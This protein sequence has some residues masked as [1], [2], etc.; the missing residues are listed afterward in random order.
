MIRTYKLIIFMMSLIIL[1]MS[2]VAC[3]GLGGQPEIVSTLPPPQPASLPDTP[4]NLRLGAQIYAARCTECHGVNG[5]GDGQLVQDGSVPNPGNFND[6]AFMMGKSPLNY[7]NVITNG[8]IQNLMPPWENALTEEERWAVAMY[9]YTLHYGDMTQGESLIS[10]EIP[11]FYRDIANMVTLTDAVL[12]EV[13]AQGEITTSPTWRELSTEQQKQA[14]AYVRSL[15]LTTDTALNGTP[16][17]VT[18]EEIPTQNTDIPTATPVASLG[19]GNVRG[20]VSAG[21]GGMTLPDD[22]V[23]TL[24][25]FDPDINE[26]TY[27]TTIQPDYSFQFEDIEFRSDRVY[28]ATTEYNGWTFYSR[29]TPADAAFDELEL[30]IVV[31]ETTNDANV[32]DVVSRLTQI[33]PSNNRFL[34]MVELV[35]FINTSDK[36][37]VGENAIPGE[38]LETMQFNLPPGAVVTL[39][40]NSRYMVDQENFVVT[41]MFPIPPGVEQLFAISYLMPYDHGAI[42]EYPIN[43]A[44]NGPMR[45]LIN[46]ETIRAQAPWIEP[47]GTEVL[48]GVA[49]QVYG[50][51]L[52]L[53]A[54]ET[55]RYELTGSLPGVGTSQDTSVIT[56][57]RL[58]PVVV[59]VV[60]GLFILVGSAIFILN[61]RTRVNLAIDK[62]KLMDALL[63][64]IAEL[65]AQHEAGEINHDLYHHRRKQLK[66][67][68]DQL[69]GDDV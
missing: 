34:E 18:T 7:F 6:P 22:L 20:S 1:A 14:I 65:D 66:A 11:A 55:I 44:F 13:F 41:D 23:V 10:G 39:V 16:Q 48:G 47:L 69:T 31:Y 35:Y 56:A 33:Q 26:T 30:N 37:Y 60:V 15:S 24:R 5:A 2:L 59:L 51:N 54:G 68:L 63:Q 43:Q 3:G 25:V 19:R 61:R 9:V 36:L 62:N 57:D 40:D 58:V 52:T 42:I 17:P 67:R 21:T 46:S 32:I 12:E 53:Q 8:R 28:L 45:L 38:P 29:A 27:E 49:Y 4:P 64:Q 50:G